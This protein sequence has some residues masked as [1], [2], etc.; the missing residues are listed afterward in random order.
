M[1]LLSYDDGVEKLEAFAYLWFSFFSVAIGGIL[2][3][4]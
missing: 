4:R 3:E 1:G 2:I